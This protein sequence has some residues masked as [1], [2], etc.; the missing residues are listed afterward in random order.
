M[1]T[2]P[3]N[4]TIPSS[5]RPVTLEALDEVLANKIDAEGGVC[6]S[7]TLNSATIDSSSGLSGANSGFGQ[8]QSAL[9]AVL[10]NTSSLSS[11]KKSTSYLSADGSYYS[12][13]VI[14]AISGD[15]SQAMT[16][17][18]SISTVSALA[19]VAQNAVS[20]TWGVLAKENAVDH[21]CVGL[22]YR[23]DINAAW[24]IYNNQTGIATP[25]PDNARGVAIP[26]RNTT[27]SGVFGWP[28][29]SQV[30]YAGVGLHYRSDIKA[31][32]FVYNT[33]AGAGQDGSDPSATTGVALLT[34]DNRQS[35]PAQLSGGASLSDV[36]N[37][38][39]SLMTALINTGV[40]ASG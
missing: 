7:L 22:H 35:A 29:G 13:R 23:S 17:N 33:T 24:L 28:V 11:L 27:V 39:N 8:L 37:T 12:G 15:V 32:W 19:G 34:A 25:Q 30:D 38:V 40:L 4:S 5:A 20:G 21:S 16:G 26:L 31:A 1:S 36:I 6:S 2:L 14:G 9:S 10:L 18:G 3:P